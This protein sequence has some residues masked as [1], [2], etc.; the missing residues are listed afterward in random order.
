MTVRRLIG[1]SVTQTFKLRRMADSESEVSSI[2]F[3]HM[4][5]HVRFQS[6]VHSFSRSFNHLTISVTLN[7]GTF[8]MNYC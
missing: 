7:E 6:M 4:H 1:W 2:Q 3:A 8:A 5:S